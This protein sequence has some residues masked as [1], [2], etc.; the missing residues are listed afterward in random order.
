MFSQARPFTASNSKLAYAQ[1]FSRTDG[2]H[3]EAPAAARHHHLVAK[4]L[5]RNG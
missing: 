1:A 4:L 5:R 3:A 2:R